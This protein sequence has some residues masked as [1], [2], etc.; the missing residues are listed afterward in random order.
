MSTPV[1]AS[2]IVDL[3]QA[4]DQN[5]DVYDAA[6]QRHDRQHSIMSDDDHSDVMGTPSENDVLCYSF[7]DD[8]WRPVQ[9]VISADG[10]TR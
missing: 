2:D 8:A 5:A 10:G 1:A 7:D 4:I 9:I 6:Q 3:Q